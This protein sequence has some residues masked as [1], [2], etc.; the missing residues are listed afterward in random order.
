MMLDCFCSH[1]SQHSEALPIV[2]QP[3]HLRLEGPAVVHRW[4]H[5]QEDEFPPPGA[6]IEYADWLT[7]QQLDHNA[8]VA[9]AAGACASTPPVTTLA[10]T[11]EEPVP[12]ATNPN[13][14]GYQQLAAATTSKVASSSVHAP[15]SAA[16]SCRIRRRSNGASRRT[17]VNAAQTITALDP[18]GG[19]TGRCGGRSDAGAPTMDAA[20]ELLL[21]E[22]EGAAFKVAKVASEP[23]DARKHACALQ[24]AAGSAPTACTNGAAR[25]PTEQADAWPES[26]TVQQVKMREDIIDASGSLVAEAGAAAVPVATFQSPA[27]M[28]LGSAGGLGKWK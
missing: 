2:L 12:A 8:A 18:V 7:A 24:P 13:G 25:A 11:V 16:A 20:C 3:Q 15:R 28:Q 21:T 1:A 17:C 26:P 6:V 23:L 27:A 14:C 4:A 19:T 10:A 5:A 9:L 22:A